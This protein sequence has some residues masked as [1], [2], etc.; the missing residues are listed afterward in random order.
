MP[1]IKTAQELFAG[2]F[3]EASPEGLPQGAS[4]RAINVDYVVGAVGPRPGKRSAFTFP[5]DAFESNAGFTQ[6]VG[7]AGVSWSGGSVTLNQAGLCPLIAYSISGPSSPSFI[8]NVASD[9]ISPLVNEM[10]VND[11]VFFYIQTGTLFHADTACIGITDSLGTIF[12]QIGTRLV[13][14]GEILQVFS[15]PL[16]AAVAAGGAYSFSVTYNHP[17]IEVEQTVIGTVI[18]GILPTVSHLNEG[19]FTEPGP[20]PT[21]YSGPP[22]TTLATEFV[23]S[24]LLS[25]RDA[26]TDPDYTNLG[27][28]PGVSGSLITAH[29]V[30]PDTSDFHSPAGTYGGNYHGVAGGGTTQVAMKN[31]SFPVTHDCGGGGSPLSQTLQATNFALNIPVDV[32]QGQIASGCGSTYTIIDAPTGLPILGVEV[33]LTGS[34][35]AQPPD[36]ELLVQ[37][38]LPDGT[39]SPDIKTVQMPL[40]SGTVTLGSP[41]DLWGFTTDQLTAALLNDPNFTVN[42][43]AQAPGGEL[44]TFT[45]SVEVLVAFSVPDPPPDVNYMKSFSETGG[46]LTSLVLGSNGVMYK[47]DA[48]NAPNL[49]APLFS[50][51]FP[52]SFAQSATLDNREY[53]A[54]SDLVNGTD[55][56]RVYSPP[57]FDRLSQV[58]PGAPPTGTGSNVGGTIPIASI[59]QPTVK[60][61]PENPGHISGFLWSAGPGSTAAGNVLTVYWGR[62]S[63]PGPSA[64]NDP[65]LKVGVGVT[66]SGADTA[67]PNNQFNGQLIDANYTVTSV[68]EG[69]PPG[70]TF[71][72]WYFTVQVPVSQFVN[73][74]D[75][76]EANAPDGNY[77]VTTATLTSTLPIPNMQIGSTM[78]IAGTGGSPAA[79]YDGSWLVTD[80]T[81]AAQLQITSTVLAGNIATYGYIVISGAT[82][83]IG[84]KV[85]V[86]E[87]LNGGGIF[88]VSNATIT[89]TSPGVFSISLVSPDIP[90]AAESGTGIVAG[91]IFKFEPGQPVGNIAGIGT[92]VVAGI[93]AFGIRKLCYSF[94]TRNG[95]LTQPSPIATAD[96]IVGSTG[97]AVSNLSPGPENVIARVIHFTGA[98]G[99]Q[100]YNIPD[101][102]FVTDP[103]TGQKITN[104]STWVMDNTTTNVVL[105]FSDEVLL[106]ADEI[107]IQGNNLFACYELGSCTALV[108]YS[109]AQRLAAIGEQNKVFNFRNHSFDGGVGGGAGGQT[110]PLGWTV[111]PANGAGGSVVTSPIFGNAYQIT[112]STGSP[113]AVY[114]MISQPA[115]KDEFLVDIINASTTYSV[116]VTAAVSAL[117]A[118]GNLIIDLY[119]PLLHTALGT[120]SL[121]LSS[122]TT[123]M[124]LFSGTLLTT[125]LAPV[126][127]DLL[128]RIWAQNIPDG[129]VVTLDREEAFP[130]EAPNLHTQVIF[131][132]A[133]NF[134][135]FDRLTGVIKPAQNSQPIKSCFVEFDTFYMGKVNSLFSTAD[136][137]TTEPVVADAGWGVRTVS[138]SIGTTSVYG[139]TTAIDQPNSGEDWAILAGQPG[140]YIYDG[141]E[142]VKLSE[143]I[144]SIWNKINWDFEHTIWTLNDIINRRILFGVP[145]K[146]YWL[147]AYGNVQR[148]TWLPAGVIPDDPA[149]TTPNVIL[150]LNYKQLNTASALSSSVGVHRSYS[151][152]LLASEI[153]R[154]WALWTIKAPSAA[155]L[156]RSDNT[157]PVFV[158]N[159]DGNGK[160]FQLIEGLLEDDGSPFS[161]RY[162]TSSFL[163]RSDA[164]AQNVGVL[165]CGY[166]TMTLII[167]GQG[168]FGIVAHNN[169][170]DGAGTRRLLP[171]LTFPVSTFGDAEVPLDEEANRLFIEFIAQCVGSA[172]TLSGMTML[173]STSGFAPYSGRNR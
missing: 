14:V 169:Y 109:G 141:G 131:S 8:G 127:Q 91:T 87:T 121:P 26:Q 60:S 39:L 85:T 86:G 47:E 19:V 57:N 58:G 30:S 151:G 21:P 133:Q 117:V 48:I 76:I 164:Q 31:M 53:I 93:F 90:S 144:Q 51:I 9:V 142:P 37:L 5:E 103:I 173:M 16:T 88:N 10:K 6:S 104:D 115:Y 110:Y 155:F 46:E 45:V 152:K 172:Y 160:I 170:V 35:S 136:N 167:D 102:V 59:T 124:Q 147:D 40:V 105:S 71:G 50:N 156:T 118:S 70:A 34:Q 63:P 42:I 81:N 75:H 43:V 143:E 108:P 119:S 106:A 100:F 84:S 95:F 149:P 154:K 2:L 145:L 1:Q 113:Q 72:R 96:I 128:L 28:T 122:L 125:M 132:Y 68:G 62:S 7:P 80:S 61:D 89:S 157:A 112:N 33:E 140:A 101:P 17:V 18:R 162:I 97:I 55:I 146:T 56:P 54:I 12:S 126:P 163:P 44:V 158:G 99:G 168:S 79:G 166:D 27:T 13:A 52:D 171:D 11:V 150:E 41:T 138:Q 65:D 165:R 25:P 3:T 159:S 74:A 32:P 78:E 73:Q 66:I 120:F 94:L 139:I 148:G 24:F 134:E 82:P 64:T 22:I 153:T 130:T 135:A 23:M 83:A 92:V 111:D 98:N 4:P 116:R 123:R 38:Q 20:P 107:D 77:Q 129:A 36:A 137:G 29:Y 67:N 49:L 69:I 161:E 15:G 114:G